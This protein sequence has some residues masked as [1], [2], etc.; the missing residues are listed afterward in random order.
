[1]QGVLE[2]CLIHQCLDIILEPLKQ[3]ACIRCMMSDPVGNLRYC[4]TPLALYIVDIPKVAMLTCQF[5][6]GLPSNIPH[7]HETYHLSGI[8][9]TP[10]AL[11]HWHH[12]FY[13]HDV[14]WCIRIVGVQELDF[15]FSILQPLVTFQHF[16]R[17]I[18]T[19]KQVTGRAQQDM[20]HYIV[21]VIADAT[22]LGIVR[23]VWVLMDFCYLSQAVTVDGTQCQ[24]ILDALKTF[25]DHKH[26]II[27]HGGYW[28]AKSKDIINWYIPKL[29]LMQ[30]VVPSIYQVTHITVIKDPAESMNNQNYDPQICQYLDHVEKCRHFHTAMSIAEPQ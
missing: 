24:K 19:L 11:H 29:K 15:R 10:E 22:P 21:A 14:Q 27:A 20:Q 25:H 8:F 4:F 18:S 5:G 6:D 28:G 1:M 30:S 3:A 26:E 2:A 7:A 13:D 17:G 23:A 12:E 16:K 9:L